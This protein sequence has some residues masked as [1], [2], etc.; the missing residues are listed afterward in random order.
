VTATPKVANAAP[1][2]SMTGLVVA[3]LLLAAVGALALA[4]QWPRRPPL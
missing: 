1:L 2:T 3:A 4:R